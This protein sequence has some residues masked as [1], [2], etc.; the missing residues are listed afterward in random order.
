MQL[1]LADCDFASFTAA[2]THHKDQTD[3]TEE[4]MD[5]L[6]DLPAVLA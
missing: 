2:L 6:R 5:G 3:S 4:V 1:V